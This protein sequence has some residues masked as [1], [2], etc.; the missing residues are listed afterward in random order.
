MPSR[1]RTSL[2]IFEVGFALESLAGFIVLLGGGTAFPD[3]ALIVFLSPLFSFLG[4]LWLWI[5][6]SEWN[7]AHSRRVGHVNAAFGLSLFAAVLAAGLVVW[8]A[9]MGVTTP[10]GWAGLAFGTAVGSVLALTFLT[11]V[12]VASHLV[13]PVGE[14]SMAFG[15]LW[16]LLLSI[17]IGAALIP[18]LTPLVA[19]VA[20]HN[21][22]IG[23]ILAPITLLASLFAL[24]YLAFLVAFA[25]AYGRVGRGPAA[26][27]A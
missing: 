14:I 27:R 2:A 17:L 5:G 4:L 18:E 3:R 25:D 9:Q 11:Y 10:P 22:A 15:L 1:L 7:E 21:P 19:D 24:S 6:R 26:S 23:P 20:S 16:A 12:L 13:G 8:L